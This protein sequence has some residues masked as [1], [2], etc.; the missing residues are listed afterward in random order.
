[1]RNKKG[2]QTK[3][4][5]ANRNVRRGQVRKNRKVAAARSHSKNALHRLADVLEDMAANV[6]KAG[7]GQPANGNGGNGGGPAHPANPAAAVVKVLRTELRP[8][9][10]PKTQQQ[11]AA[12]RTAANIVT[13]M[14]PPEDPP[15]AQQGVNP[16]FP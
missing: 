5:R 7:N 9:R 11:R 4:G 16:Q 15:D 8:Q 14:V 3:T 1:M 12:S 6:A 13:A 10:L 2:K